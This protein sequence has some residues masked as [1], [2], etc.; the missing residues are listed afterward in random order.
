MPDIRN[1]RAKR[2]LADGEI[3]S[4][5]FGPVDGDLIEHIGHAGFDAVWLE[6]EHGP[7]DFADLPDL[8]RACDLWG[9][10]A[11]VRVTENDPGL[12][13]RSLDCGANAVAAPHIETAEQ[14]RAL[15][16]AA[17]FGPIGQRGSYNGRRSLGASDWFAE[18]NDETFVMAI[19]EDVEG[20]E[21]LPEIL[22]VDEIDAYFVAP[23][24]LSQSMG[25]VGQHDHPEVSAA[26][27]RAIALITA[28]GRLPGTLATGRPIEHFVDLGARLFLVPWVPWVLQGGQLFLDGPDAAARP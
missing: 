3:V 9:V 6:T 11:L 20:I 16:G 24:D 26:V 27:D 28:A 23:V 8:T 22:E 4:V 25:L 7:I 10:T 2:K 12:I 13:Y 17:K 15:V 1:N 21:N 18:A 14:A 19:I 5:A